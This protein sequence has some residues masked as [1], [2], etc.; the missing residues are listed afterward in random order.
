M[1]VHL[2]IQPFADFFGSLHT[3]DF[4]EFRARPGAVVDDPDSFEEMRRYLVERYAGVE[5]VYS[6]VE[7]GG[8]VVDCV[9]AEQQSYLR[10]TGR[11]LSPPPEPLTGEPH[12][13]GRRGPPEFASP[14][15][16]TPPT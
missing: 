14:P 16:R 4:E 11:A 1:A 7:S 9:P 10:R 15:P 13:E 8:E 12:S 6:F 2:A 3:A 5:S